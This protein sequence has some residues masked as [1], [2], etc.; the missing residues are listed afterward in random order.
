MLNI[1]IILS[2]YPKIIIVKKK[3]IV[4]IY[5]TVADPFEKFKKTININNKQ[6]SY[7]NLP[8]FGPEYGNV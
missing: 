6:Y 3:Y 1:M 2:S 8:E 7:F 4:T 5:C